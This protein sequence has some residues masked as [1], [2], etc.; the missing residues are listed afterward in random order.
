MEK[1]ELIPTYRNSEQVKTARREHALWLQSQQEHG[2]KYF[3]VDECGCGMYTARTRGRSVIGLPARGVTDSQ[4]TP[5][6][7]M[8]CA[9]TPTMGLIHSKTMIGG[10]KQSDFDDFITALFSIYFG[11]TLE[12]TGNIVKRF[13]ILDNA[14]FLLGSIPT[15]TELIR[16]PPY[17]YELNPIEM[18]FN[19]LKAYLNRVLSVNGPITASE[20]KTMVGARRQFLLN[21]CP[22][23]LVQITA[24]TTLS[25]YFMS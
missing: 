19:S 8:L 15:N 14:P 1:L 21:C 2:A 22:E 23:A 7:T 20:G 12:H 5:H 11:P 9:I 13:I 3:Y 16:L 17:S 4:R 25:S 6:I 24:A 10:A 18:C